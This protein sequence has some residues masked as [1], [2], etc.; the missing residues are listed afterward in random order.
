MAQHTSRDAETQDRFVR[1]DDGEMH[2]VEEGQPDGPALL[3]IHGSA[4][5][6]VCWD[7]VVP[8]LAGA[9][10]VIRVDLLGCG[11][12]TADGRDP[13]LGDG[14]ARLGRRATHGANDHL[15]G[16]NAY[17]EYYNSPVARN[18]GVQWTSWKVAVP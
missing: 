15:D 14:A 3:L 18:R 6:L 17:G 10:R 5:S 13:G 16:A 11:R 1:I 8:S 9:F 2:V 12:S 4:A 7:L